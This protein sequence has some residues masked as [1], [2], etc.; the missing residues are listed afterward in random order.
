MYTNSIVY[1]LLVSLLIL[2]S[3]SA[4][5]RR[6][7]D[8]PRSDGTYQ[9]LLEVGEC[10]LYGCVLKER[11]TAGRMIHQWFDINDDGT[12]DRIVVW[13]PIVD[14]TYGTF[15]TMYKTKLCTGE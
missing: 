5:E 13:K 10:D 14:P 11:T 15:Y 12:C 6:I 9:L 2:A 8:L 1:I 4:E 7:L 3:A